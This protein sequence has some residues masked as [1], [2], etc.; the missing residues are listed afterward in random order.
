MAR[1]ESMR[2]FLMSRR[3][4]VSPEQ[5]GLTTD[6]RRRR[7][8]GLRR[9]EVALLAGISTEYYVQIERGQLAGVS[10]KVLEAVS[11]ALRLDPVEHHHFLELVAATRDPDNRSQHPLG[12]APTVPPGVQRVMNS[13]TATVAIVLTPHLD[14]ASAN[15]LG[16]ALFAPVL[17][18]GANLARY[19]FLDPSAVDL[20]P[21][22]D[23]AVDTCIRLLRVEAG[24]SP[25]DSALA[26]LIADLSTRGP[27]FENRW[28]QY[29]VEPHTRG[30][31]TFRHPAVGILALHFEVFVIPAT[32][33][34]CLAT[35][36]AD[37]GTTATAQLSALSEWVTRNSRNSPYVNQESWTR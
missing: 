13:M 27:E 23:D 31:K 35:Y 7:V 22:W 36:D 19:T 17:R 5:L 37:P 28:A 2:E 3:A 32:P 29:D 34:L 15:P 30:T 25:H 9:E 6:Q 8:P 14:I 4:R 21:D 26:E 24:R 11:D 33:G 18:S 20:F 12:D 10:D 1:A 16:H